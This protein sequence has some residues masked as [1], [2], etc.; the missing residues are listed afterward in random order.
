[1]HKGLDDF[2]QKVDVGINRLVIAL[3]VVGGLLG[4]SIL[5]AFTTNGPQL[6]GVYFLAAIGFI[7]SA[8]M[9]VWLMWG[10]IRSGRL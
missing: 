3:V 4:S 7:A 6:F 5:A 2:M 9:A 1:M 8:V 10:V